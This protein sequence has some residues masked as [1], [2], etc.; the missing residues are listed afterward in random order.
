MPKKTKKNSMRRP[1]RGIRWGYILLFLLIIIMMASLIGGV[2]VAGWVFG[3]AKE[4][5]E[6][7]ADDLIME[8]NSY[9]YDRYG[10][11]LGMLHAGQ[12]RDTVEL[13]D[14][15]PFLIDAVLASEDIRFYDHNGVDFRSVMRA[16]MVDARDSI[17]ARELT[18]TQG[19]S[20]ISMQ[21]VRNVVADT[22]KSLDRKVKEALLA[23]EFEKNINSKDE[24]L[25]LYMNMIYLGP[26]IYGF[27]SAASYYFNKELQ[28][29]TLSEAALMVGILRNAD[30][31]SPYRHP[32]RAT[33]IRNT[34]LNSLI[35]FD[36]GKYGVKAA[37][38]MKDELV[39]YDAPAN[40]G[41]DYEHPWFVDHVLMEATSILRNMDMP[42][43]SLF[44][45]G[46]HIYTTMDPKLQTAMENA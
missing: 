44:T 10:R 21:L 11:Q 39:V 9:V 3:L 36:E 42:P 43:E 31:Y 1:K 45:A 5:P 7:T 16:V 13:A 25:Y 14:M 30:Y 20:T 26:R 23:M 17:K 32:E 33:N 35:V 15:P 34:V 6:I 41:T 29:I 27:N 8:Q 2:M 46:L 19:A 12:N 28:D 40:T 37:A 24:I 38:A 18:F 22:K 4:L